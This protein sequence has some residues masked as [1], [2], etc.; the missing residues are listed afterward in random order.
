MLVVF[1][2]VYPHEHICSGGIENTLPPCS[3][4]LL[5]RNECVL[6][7]GLPYRSPFCPD[8]RDVGCHSVPLDGASGFELGLIFVRHVS[9]GHFGG[10]Y[11]FPIGFGG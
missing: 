2:E 8:H 5:L 6:W 9:V 7:C 11:F 10:D 1:M 3:L 4:R